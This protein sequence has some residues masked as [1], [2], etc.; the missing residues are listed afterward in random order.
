MLI[1]CIR[2]VLI[3]KFEFRLKNCGVLFLQRSKIKCM[4]GLM[5]SLCI[6]MKETRDALHILQIDKENRKIEAVVLAQTELDP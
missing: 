2:S 6:V 5:I 1:L 3:S 4:N